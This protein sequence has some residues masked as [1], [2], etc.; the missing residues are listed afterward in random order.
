M[1]TIFPVKSL[2]RNIIHWEDYLHTLTPVELHNG[3]WFKREDYFAPLG[4]GS[5]NGTKLR[6]CL[7]LINEYAVKTGKKGVINGAII[8]S[9]QHPKVAAI[10]KHYNLHAIHITGT[11]QIDGNRTLEI[12]KQLGA[13]FIASSV[14]YAKTL[15]AKVFDLHETQYSDYFPLETNITVSAN[16]NTIDKIEAFHEVTSHQI[17]NIPA[18]AEV[19]IVP[20]GSCNSV[21]SV[22]YGIARFRPANLKKIILLGIGNYG[23]KSPYYIKTRLD[24]IGQVSGIN[25]DEIFHYDYGFEKE[26]STLYGSGLN[27]A[28]YTID[29]YDVNGG[30]PSMFCKSPRPCYGGYTQYSDLM[31]FTW[32]DIVM[33]PRYEGK[34]FNFM[35]D[36]PWYFE[37]YMN[38][39]TM[40]WIVGGEEN[41]I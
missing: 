20:A 9:P 18:D 3:V 26:E 2:D 25:M 8:A 40:F 24:S 27:D 39:K 31:P 1:N 5:I 38:N 36:H 23:S 11:A 16:R 28:Q 6:Q 15:E 17:K 34:C 4:Y 12:A 30:C 35:K 7:W 10:C 37:R 33:H 41:L 22:L 13:E 32:N 14:G 21:A 19:L 29:R